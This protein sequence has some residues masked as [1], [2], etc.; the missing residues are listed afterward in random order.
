[1]PLRKARQV[2]YAVYIDGEKIQF[3]YS[4]GIYL[5]LANCLKKLQ[6]TDGSKP[7]TLC[8]KT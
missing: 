5:K 6:I 2:V 7:V 1:M 4:S 8:S 3:L